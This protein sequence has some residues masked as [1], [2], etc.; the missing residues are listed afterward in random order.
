MNDEPSWEDFLAINNGSKGCSF[1][2]S[3]SLDFR[4][5]QEVIYHDWAPPLDKVGR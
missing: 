4:I 3:G 5:G 2:G 1:V